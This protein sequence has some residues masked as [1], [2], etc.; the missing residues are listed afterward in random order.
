MTFGSDRRQSRH[1]PLSRRLR[2]G[3]GAGVLCCALYGLA[4]DDAPGLDLDLEEL[5]RVRV[6]RTPKFSVNAETTPSSV[7]VLT[8][9]EIRAYGW[10]T[11][12]DALRTLNGYT[13][14]SDHTYSFVGVRGISVPGDYRSRLQVLIDGIPVNENIYGSVNFENSFPLDMGLVDRIEVVRG[15][16]ASVYGGDSSLGV[17][18]VVT[19]G[20]DS[21]KGTEVALGLGSGRAA[22]AR[23]SWGGATAGGADLV[24]SYSGS[25]ARGHRVNF[26]ELASAGIDTTASG[27]EGD[28][29]DKFFGRMKLGGW[30]ATLVHSERDRHV[31]TGSYA[32]EFNEG[33]HRETDSFTLAE[34]AN[35]LEFDRRN[36]LH[37]RLYGGR[38]AYTGDFPYLYPPYV[39]NRDRAVGEWLGFESRILSTAWADHRWIAGVEYKDNLRQYQRNDDE[40]FGCFGVGPTPCLDDRR[41]SRQFSVY[42]QD[43]M[44]V[45]DATRLTLGLRHDHMTDMPGHWSPRLGLVHQSENA[46]IFK[47]LYASAFSDPT[48][49]QR[50]YTT[51]GFPVGNLVLTPESVRSLDLTWEGRLGPRTK[52]MSSLYFFRV[53]DMLGVDQGTG[54]TINLPPTVSRGLEFELQHRWASGVALRAGYTFQSVHMERTRVE[55]I[56][57]H[58]LKGNLT[59]PLAGNAWLAALEGEALSRRPTALPGG[60]VAGHVLADAN[61]IHRPA[62][63]RWEAN[64]GIHNLTNRRYQDPVALDATL[65]GPRDRMNQLG[66]TVRLGLTAHF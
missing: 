13:V 12:A 56:A 33:R 1:A 58:A 26:P 21:L 64:L 27:V 17:V 39:V 8:R 63:A 16:S 3:L 50:Y 29:A 31:P 38:Y 18:N 61:L 6:I 28:R 20:A 57:R 32:T 35:D 52:A 59:I 44:A 14:S 60:W 10:Q 2:A 22:D 4:G 46:G 49:Y 41:K 42:A 24:L 45:A 23:V 19:R 11:L 25:G 51:P 43:E 36:S 66:R 30:R 9:E 37:T 40:G 54:T 62:G 7:S 15:P 65:G 48:V 55:N 34:V 47:L 5:L 53:R